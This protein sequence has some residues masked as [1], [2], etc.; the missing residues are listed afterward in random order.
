MR[1]STQQFFMQNLSNV[2][3]SNAQIFKYQQ[4]MSTGKK[5]SK[6]SDDP[7][8]ATQ[9][10]KFERAI[11]RNEV[12]SRNVDVSER[13][14]KQEETTLTL[15]TE[16][17]LR[18]KDLAIQANNGSLSPADQ[19]II[20]EELK[21]LMGQ[22]AG[23]VNTQ[24]AQGEYLFSGFKGQTQ[25]YQ[26]NASDDYVYRG[27]SGQRFLDVGENTSVAATDPGGSIFGTGDDNLLNA[28][29]EMAAILDDPNTDMNAFNAEVDRV[30]QFF[31]QTI[32]TRSQIGARLKVLEDQREQLADIKLFTKN[33]LSS[34]QDT[35]YY[36]ATSKLM[37]EQNA[38]Q[39]T[40]ATFG[41]IQQLT[42]F[43]FVS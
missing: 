39:A 17:T 11:A 26:L 30:D 3:Q 1:L 23:A 15:I 12:F 28:V 40:Y 5:L 33:T 24:D 37:L 14:L 21:Q 10:N 4:Q 19:R 16:S 2:Q 32:T 9:I 42:L 34:F 20:A 13:R 27:D 25:P 38:L 35:D 18:I 41:K 29:K 43:N 8:A 36:E 6:P 31:E 22:L 7:L